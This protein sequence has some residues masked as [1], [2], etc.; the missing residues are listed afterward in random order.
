M[1]I[2]DEPC[3]LVNTPNPISQLGFESLFKDHPYRT[4][5][6]TTSQ[7]ALALGGELQPALSILDFDAEVDFFFIQELMSRCPLTRVTLWVGSVSP[8]VALH[9]MRVGVAGLIGKNSGP[10]RFLQELWEVHTGHIVVEPELNERISAAQRTK[11]TPREFE[12]VTLVAE[13]FHNKAIATKLGITVNT[14]KAYM[15]RLFEKL[16]VDSRHGLAVYG[17]TS[18]SMDLAAMRERLD[19]RSPLAIPAA[20]KDNFANQT[21]T[22]CMAR[23]M[24]ALE[25]GPVQGHKAEHVD[26]IGLRDRA[27][28]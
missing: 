7:E 9:S 22:S 13:G 14:V 12:L 19:H 4:A 3:I 26:D 20:L 28:G 18:F 27:G 8:E 6:A 21:A 5:F 23:S 25:H 1:N 2:E 15:G 24:P 16:G 17:L 11:L 10:K